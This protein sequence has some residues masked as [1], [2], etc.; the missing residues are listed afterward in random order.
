[1]AGNP[2]AVK[3]PFPARKALNPCGTGPEGRIVLFGIIRVNT[4]AME[5]SLA[6]G[7]LICR[8]STKGLVGI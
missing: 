3:D 4:K 2:K 5:R 1:M 8:Y 7:A 6:D